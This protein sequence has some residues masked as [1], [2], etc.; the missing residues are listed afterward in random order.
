MNLN[1][2]F[3]IDDVLTCTSAKVAERALFFKNKGAILTAVK[4]HYVFPGVIEFM[5]LLFQTE[6]VKVSFFSAGAKHR[7]DKFVEELLTLSLGE[8]KY[9]EVKHRVRI[10]SHEDLTRSSP[11]ECRK[12]FDL[13]GIEPW[14]NSQKDIS[15]VLEE[16]DLLE[17]AVL[18]DNSAENAA[19]GQIQ[20]LLYVA[21]TSIT[22]YRK[23]HQKIGFYNPDG[24]KYMR[25]RM[26]VGTKYLN[27]ESVKR[28]ESI[29]FEKI[30]DIFKLSFINKKTLELETL[31]L[32]PDIHKE[33]IHKLESLYQESKPIDLHPMAAMCSG[34]VSPYNIEDTH[35]ELLTL[36]TCV[37]SIEQAAPA[38]L[39]APPK[40][41]QRI[42]TLAPV[43]ESPEE[44][45]DQEQFQCRITNE[46]LVGRIRELVD[47]HDGQTRKI[48]RKINRIYYAAGLLFTAIEFSKSNGNSLS[49]SLF[50]IQ[51]NFRENSKTY[52]CD[53]D[54]LHYID[55]IYE[56]GLAKLREVNANL[57]FTSP[58]NYMECVQLPTSDEEFLELQRTVQNE[59]TDCNDED[60]VDDGD[61]F[62]WR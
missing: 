36:T 49:E 21:P 13:F 60:D 39:A 51:F 8:L 29:L 45:E 61:T 5:K 16:G 41:L 7:N 57:Q 18:I 19:C 11:R 14:E 23:L 25:Y 62:M 26:V 53:F 6:H 59:F 40:G 32:T 34:C 52:E 37:D 28:G 4:T 2:V 20:N 10:L 3:D 33:L 43:K 17:N 46:S 50:D 55:E 48:C 22:N 35:D 1:I 47:S 42:N 15:K 27:K 12:A 54:R 56:F 24:Y 38:T 58:H 31:E 30:N 44:E 9:N